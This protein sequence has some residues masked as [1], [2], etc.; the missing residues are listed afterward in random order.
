MHFKK[1]FQFI[2]EHNIGLTKIQ[3]KFELGLQQ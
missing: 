1:T 3:F 2:H